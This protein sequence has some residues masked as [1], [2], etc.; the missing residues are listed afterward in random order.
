MT[1]T[2]RIARH[3]TDLEIHPVA[4]NIGAEIRN[5]SFG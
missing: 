4:G 2:Q 1:S 5:I 3:D